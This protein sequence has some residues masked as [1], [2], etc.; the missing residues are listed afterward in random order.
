MPASPAPSLSVTWSGAL[1][2]EL[3]LEFA[4]GEVPTPEQLVD[5]QGLVGSLG[6]R[7]PLPIL[8]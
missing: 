4:L 2:Q 8:R 3:L 1:R 7:L 5:L 6:K